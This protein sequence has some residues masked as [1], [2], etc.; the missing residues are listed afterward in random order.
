MKFSS[1]PGT[2]G[3]ADNR[4]RLSLIHLLVEV[5]SA[6]ILRNILDRLFGKRLKRHIH[7]HAH[8]AEVFKCRCGHSFVKERR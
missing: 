2:P 8:V 7:S 5:S 3:C 1:R 4:A 6:M